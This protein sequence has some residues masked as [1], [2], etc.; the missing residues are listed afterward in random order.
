MNDVDRS[1]HVHRLAEVTEQLAEWPAVVVSSRVILVSG[2]P[3]DVVAVGLCNEGSYAV[4]RCTC[5]RDTTVATHAHDE[6]EVVTLLAGDVVM[7][8]G[9]AEYRMQV[10][11]S[12]RIE[13]GV[14]HSAK[15]FG[16]GSIV[17]ATT[18]PASR[19]FPLG[20]TGRR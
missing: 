1:P 6:L 17:L 2:E 10:G 4:L 3:H 7:D 12:L 5:P 19:G 16:A 9:G 8:I 15:H 20:E 11:D 14:P 18:I 13:S